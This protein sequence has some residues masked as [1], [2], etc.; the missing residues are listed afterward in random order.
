M[1]THTLGLCNTAEE[2][3][4][5]LCACFCFFFLTVKSSQQKLFMYLAHS[6]Q[7]MYISQQVQFKAARPDLRS[8]PR[9]GCWYTLKKNKILYVFFQNY[10]KKKQVYKY[11][12]I[13]SWLGKLVVTVR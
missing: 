11:A 8:V 7:T 2:L 3:P 4:P 1:L 5:L 9:G 13:S 6:F 12:K 10:N